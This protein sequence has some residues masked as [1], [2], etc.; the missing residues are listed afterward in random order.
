MTGRIQSVAVVLFAVFLSSCATLPGKKGKGKDSEP[1]AAK[2][3]PPVMKIPVGTIHHVDAG[4]EF[5]LIRSSRLLQIEP[6]TMITV[7][8]NQGETTATL[9]VSPARKGQFLTADIISGNPVAGQQTAM[10]YTASRQADPAP[11]GVPG[12]GGGNDIQV[13]E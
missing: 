7:F 1:A 10:D 13:L 2:P 9:K 12:S 8:G 6:D 11:G 5:V 4:G 3:E